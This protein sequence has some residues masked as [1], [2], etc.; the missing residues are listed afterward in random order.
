MQ[1]VFTRSIQRFDHGKGIL[2]I[3]CGKEGNGQTIAA[4]HN[5]HK[6]ALPMWI[7]ET[8]KPVHWNWVA[9]FSYSASLAVSLAIWRGV[10]RAVEH[11]VK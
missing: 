5:N 8:D 6:G 11:L 3:T 2:S 4:F 1:G 9:I 7:R 10:F